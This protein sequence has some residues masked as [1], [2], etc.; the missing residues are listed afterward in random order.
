MGQKCCILSA[1][2]ME[3][4]KGSATGGALLHQE[5]SPIPS[6]TSRA[7]WPS[8]TGG[9]STPSPHWPCPGTQ[10]PSISLAGP[11]GTL[12]SHVMQNLWTILARDCFSPK[13][14][15][16]LTCILCLHSEQSPD[17][18][19]W[20]TN[21]AALHSRM[22]L[23][24]RSWARIIAPAWNSMGGG[25]HLGIQHTAAVEAEDTSCCQ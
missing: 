10:T 15:V 19:L 18:G 12:L 3:E 17:G 13:C 6:P 22:P 16:M 2:S 11:P 23:L 4:P 5:D 24:H 20:V 9:L 8:G 1:H 25:W 21:R 14:R 7:V